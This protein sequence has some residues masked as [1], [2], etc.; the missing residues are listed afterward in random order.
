VAHAGE[1]KGKGRAG[2]GQG[3]WVV[4]FPSSFPVIFYT[5]TFKQNYLNSIKFEFKPYTFNT[6][7]I[8]LQH[9]CTNKFIL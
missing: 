5:Q 8:M 2:L 7:K 9:E 4:F 6:N 1:R 3:V